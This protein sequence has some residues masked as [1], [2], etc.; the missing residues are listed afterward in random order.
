MKKNLLLLPLL[1]FLQ[2]CFFGESKNSATLKISS[3]F[4]FA[5]Q[6]GGAIIYIVNKDLKTQRAITTYSE[7]VTIDLQNGNW[8]FS[9]IS[10]NGAQPL[11]GTLHCGQTT[12]I[13]TDSDVDINITISPANCDSDYFSP[14]SFRTGGQTKPLR[15]I[16]CQDVSTATSNSNCDNTHRGFAESYR[17]KILAHNDIDVSNLNVINLDQS[18]TISSNCLAGTSAPDSIT[19]PSISIPFGGNSFRPSVLI[20]AFSDGACTNDKKNY[21]FPTGLKNV[22]SNFNIAT[23]LYGSSYGDVFLEFGKRYVTG[24]FNFGPILLGTTSSQTMTFYNSTSNDINNVTFSIPSPFTITSSCTSVLKKS[25]CLFTVNYNPSVAGN[26]NP[27]LL[28]TYVDGTTTKSLT[29][30]L[31]ASTLTPASIS[32]SSS[33]FNFNNVLLNTKKDQIFTLTNNGQ[34]SATS[35]SVALA[36]TNA[37]QF[38]HTTNC[39]NTLAASNSCQITVSFNP[40]IEGT[41]SGSLNFYWNNG[42]ASTGDSI[43]LSG[44]GIDLLV[45]NNPINALAIDGNILYAGGSFTKVGPRCGGG[46]FLKKSSCYGV[47]CISSN[48]ASLKV[49]PKVAGSVYSTVSDGSGGYYV[50]GS[51]SHIAGVSRKNLAHILYDGTLDLSFNPVTNDRVKAM[52]LSGSNLYIAGAFTS[53]NGTSRGWIGAVNSTTGSTTSFNPSTNGH[54]STLLLNGSTLYVGGSFTSIG[55]N[56]RNY[57]AAVDLTSGS[58]TSFDPNPNNIVNYITTDGTSLFIAGSFT[59]ILSTTRNRVASIDISSGTLNALDPNANSTVNT[60]AIN[61]STL[62]IGGSFSSVASTTR[63]RFASYDISS[64]TLNSL[65]LNANGA[66]NTF[67]IDGT[68]LYLGGLF[69]TIA[70]STRNSIASIDTLTGSLTNFDPSI[71]DS[72]GAGVETI[73]ISSGSMYVGGNFSIIEPIIRNR[74]VAFDLTTGQPTS[75]NPNINDTVRA[76]KIDNGNLY[77]TGSFTSVSGVARN[78]IASINISTGNLNSLNLNAN[79][80]VNNILIDNGILYLAGAF[81]TVGTTTRNRI[82]SFDLSTNSLTSLN[83]GADASI[84]SIQL[85]GSTLYLGGT[86]TTVA[87]STRNKVA[88]V[89]ITTGN[90]TSFDPNANGNVTSMKI[91]G[92]NIFISGM[93]TNIGGAT[94]NYL[95]SFDTSL[96]TLTTMNISLNSSVSA[97]EV[98]GSVLYI[99]GGFAM[100]GGNFIRGI[101]LNTNTLNTFNPGVNGG[102]YSLTSGNGN[103]YMGGLFSGIF[104]DARSNLAAVSP[105]Q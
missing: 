67:A 16:N 94:R 85:D 39:T 1:L 96:G 68:N 69:S 78:R 95:S 8:E 25:S 32:T 23:T 60:L 93:F 65:N 51:F 79:G 102:V 24:N 45:V 11:D 57:I 81:T 37:N 101:N 80:D 76:L 74:L 28:I 73:S 82:A 40:A 52:V 87:G 41:L 64:N 36:G 31:I 9:V 105:P 66:V 61:G 50:G 83:P 2:S 75:F 5:G 35:F 38:P 90:L 14:S 30:G 104:T 88:S 62:Y 91:V 98:V 3:S 47:A 58:I 33:S 15:L 77:V 34:V 18:S 19:N 56:S 84:N 71:A 103:L 63:N 70:G 59:N 10:W 44:S 53:I 7:K 26:Y 55:G 46:L 72:V 97:M 4:I 29:K 49:M 12:K 22:V 42:I 86:F 27:N 54:V 48:Y 17:I 43:S 92:S 99:G 89:D 100:T 21:F 6:T 20:E 13:L